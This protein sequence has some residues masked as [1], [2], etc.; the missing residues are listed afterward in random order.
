[1]RFSILLFL[2]LIC[3]PH[4]VAQSA[5]EIFEEVNRRQ[6]LIES[7]RSE[8]DIQVT[9]DEGLTQTNSMLLLT[10]V[11]EN[12]TRSL[13]V[14]TAPEDVKGTGLLTVKTPSEDTQLLYLPGLDRIQRIDSAERTERLGGSDFTFEDISP[15]DP[16]DYDLELFRTFEE[17][18]IIR[19]TPKPSANSAYGLIVFVI[20]RDTYTIRRM[21]AY[22]RPGERLK[23]VV[24][25]GFVEVQPSV[26][27]A[28]RIVMEHDA[29][30][31]QTIMTFR[32]RESQ[33]TLPNSV[34][35][36]E[37][38]RRGAEGL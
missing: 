38:L 2:G 12:S 15:R 3:I 27:Q 19:V 13:V 33:S 35:T 29:S 34:F 6:R 5:L 25:S 11:S 26:W 32:D 8:I 14:F 37:Q 10:K 16:D 31:R 36:E 7:Q 17:A 1:M 9:D 24:A 4:S 18:W 30:G 28:N 22:E 20:D 21:D 23:H